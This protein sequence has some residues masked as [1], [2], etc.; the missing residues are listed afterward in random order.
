MRYALSSLNAHWQS[1]IHS[2]T[3]LNTL[4]NGKHLSVVFETNLLRAATRPARLCT[5]LTF[6]G[7]SMLSIAWILS[8]FASIPLCETVKPRNFPDETLKA[9]LLGFSFMLYHL[10]MSKGFWRSSKCYASF[11]VLTNISSMYTST[12]RPICGQNCN[13]KFFTTVE[14]Q[15]N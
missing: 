4:K 1:S 8:G 3:F 12:F 2:N 7:S 15:T 5:S 13:H 14:N 9:H 10:S 11:A 6:F